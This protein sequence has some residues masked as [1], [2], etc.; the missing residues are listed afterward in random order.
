MRSLILFVSHQQ[1]FHKVVNY[2]STPRLVL[3]W[4]KNKAEFSWG[5]E[6][7]SCLSLIEFSF[8]SP[9]WMTMFTYKCEHVSIYHNVNVTVRK[10]YHLFDQL[11]I[12]CATLAFWASNSCIMP[13][14]AANFSF[15]SVLFSKPKPL[16]PDPGN[17][18]L[19]DS[20]TNPDGFHLVQAG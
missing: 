4:T 1:A 15:N 17:S 11:F 18:V 5:T 14:S 20:T 8:Y 10:M 3:S 13:L 19:G 16:F 2:L 7:L 12:S 6:W 9:A